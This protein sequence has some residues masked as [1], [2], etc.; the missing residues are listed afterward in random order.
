MPRQLR[1]PHGPGAVDHRR[2]LARPALGFD[3]RQGQAGPSADR[4]AQDAMRFVQE[5]D[6]APA[7]P[8]AHRRVPFLLGQVCQL[9]DR[10]GRHQRD[11][12]PLTPPV[13]LAVQE[14]HAASILQELERGFRYGTGAG[15]PV[16]LVEHPGRLLAQRAEHRLEHEPGFEDVRPIAATKFRTK[17]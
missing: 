2:E 7:R 10:S 13:H 16:G 11:E 1:G 12:H 17:V 15:E 6:L 3:L 8:P 14:L 5:H 4:A 9:S